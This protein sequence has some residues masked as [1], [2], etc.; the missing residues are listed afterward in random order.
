MNE[1][2]K[3]ETI[4][5]LVDD[6]SRSKQRAALVLGCTRRTINRLIIRYQ[7]EGKAAFRHGNKGRKPAH[8]IP[9]SVKESIVQLYKNDYPDANFTHFREILEQQEHIC[10]SVSALTSIL[11]SRYILSPKATKAKTKRM[12]QLLVQKQAH[13]S[14]KKEKET[15][16]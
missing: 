3:Y 9:N 5:A 1:Q 8:T 13:A 11:E 15:G 4:K 12:Q 7:Q 6:P 16:V 14:T 2:R 10:I